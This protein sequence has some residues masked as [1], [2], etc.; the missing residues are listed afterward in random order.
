MRS[1]NILAL[2]AI[3]LWGGILWIGMDLLKG[4]VAQRVLG[5]PAP[6]QFDFLVG[7]PFA[8]IT[9]IGGVTLIVNA[10]KRFWIASYLVSGAALIAL[11][12]YLFV[13][14]GGV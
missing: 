13:Y 2:V 3:G 11:L 12:P 5:Y 8:A 10:L 7:L 6:G 9:V 14:G 4:I 1:A